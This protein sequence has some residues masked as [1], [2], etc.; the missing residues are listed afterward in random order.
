MG[1]SIRGSLPPSYQR[2]FDSFFDGPKVVE[3][4]A[5]CDRC[6]MCDHGDPSPVAMQYFDAD[7]K[8]CTYWPIL[9]NYL[10]GAILADKDPG[11]AEGQKRLR[12]VIASRI[13]VTPWYLSRPRKLSLLMTGYQ[14]AFGRTKTLLC[15][16]Y[17]DSNPEGACSI[18]RHRENVCMTYYCKYSG[19]ARG[20]EYWTALKRYLSYVE[21]SLSEN[22]ARNVDPKVSEPQY[23]RNILTVED[24]E[25]RAPKEADYEKWWGAWVGREEE[26]YVRCH[27]WVANI[28]TAFFAKHVDGSEMGKKLLDAL[29]AKHEI[30]QNKLLPTNLVRNRRMEET[31]AGDKV[32]VTTYHRFDSFSLDKDLFEVV[33]M[34]RAEQTLEENLER[35]KNEEGIELVPELIEYLYHAGVLVDPKKVAADDAEASAE[36]PGEVNGRRAALRAILEAR[37]FASTD[38]AKKKIA[39]AD[40]AKLDGWIKNAVLA[41]SVD[42]ALSD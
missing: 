31:H 29:K 26:F 5:T 4:R 10:A 41:K 40:L 36:N 11:M 24:M 16:Y 27:N 33:G 1:D 34:F 15:P 28:P 18:W 42:D 32:V 13:S 39:A 30:L 12:K 7:T 14:E 8:C 25:D 37:G 17:D 20:F 6:S 9:P 35:L 22:A 21:R 38:E 2:I 23:R 3:T 19:G